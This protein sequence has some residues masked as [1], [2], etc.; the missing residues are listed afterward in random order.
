MTKLDVLDGLE[1]LQIATSYKIDGVELESFPADLER[2]AKVE[3][4]Y[5][6]LKG[7]KTD[8]SKIEKYEDLPDLCRAYVERIE[9]FLGVPIK[10]IG[11]GP[12]RESMLSH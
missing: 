1:E 9:D 10:W 5:E 11:N 6:T 2:L 7:W 4:G 3:V 12:A 8:I